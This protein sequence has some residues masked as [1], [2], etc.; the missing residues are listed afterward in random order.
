MVEAG[1]SKFT[2]TSWAALYGPANMPRPIVERLNKEFM[3]AAQRPEVKAA[4]EK[5]AFVQTGSTP[6]GLA[7]HTKEQYDAYR[8]ALRAAGIEP[9]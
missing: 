9:E 6:E 5:I 2:I 7:A 3:A 1:I 4:M 8:S